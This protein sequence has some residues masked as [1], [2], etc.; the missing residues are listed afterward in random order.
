MKANNAAIAAA[1]G[2]NRNHILP[3][4]GRHIKAASRFSQH[5]LSGLLILR[6]YSRDFAAETRKIR[7]LM[8]LQAI[9]NPACG[10][11]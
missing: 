1:N 3:C 10:M 5:L 11:V 2:L 7:I 6:A 8:Q 4:Q 9:L